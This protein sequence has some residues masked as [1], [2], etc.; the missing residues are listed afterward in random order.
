[1]EYG[2]SGSG[3]Y[4]ADVPGALVN[5]FH[6]SNA[7]LVR[8]DV[9]KALLSSIDSPVLVKV[10][11]K[12][13]P[14]TNVANL[15]LDATDVEFPVSYDTILKVREDGEGTRNLVFRAFK[16]HFTIYIK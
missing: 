12:L 7:V 10:L 15:T 2:P 16:R 8:G 3:A 4:V 11:G 14:E 6:Y 9:I 5:T 1:M 13:D